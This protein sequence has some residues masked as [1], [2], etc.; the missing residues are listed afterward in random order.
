MRGICWFLFLNIIKKILA[1]HMAFWICQKQ[2]SESEKLQLAAY[3]NQ[4]DN[5]R[6]KISS[7]CVYYI[8][9][10]IM[11]YG[12]F[13]TTAVTYFRQ[14]LMD[15]RILVRD[16]KTQVTWKFNSVSLSDSEIIKSILKGLWMIEVIQTVSIY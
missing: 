2:Y 4:N 14:W 3:V 12:L 9:N 15:V 8:C 6:K 11:C 10:K 5:K 7:C 13:F 16:S 1:K